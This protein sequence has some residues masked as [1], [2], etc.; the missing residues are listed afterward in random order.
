M[1]RTWTPR[2]KTVEMDPSARP[3]RIRR[4]P[5]PAA[6]VPEKALQPFSTEREA[7]IVVIGVLLFALAFFIL[8]IGI[9]DI[10]S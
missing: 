4:D 2:K 6:A 3:S 5:P 1:S 10:T 8:S 9:S 7:R